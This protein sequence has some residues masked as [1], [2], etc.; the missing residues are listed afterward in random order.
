MVWLSLTGIGV[1]VFMEWR[2]STVSLA[3]GPVG[4]ALFSGLM[5]A[6]VLLLI[7]HLR[8]VDVAWLGLVNHVACIVILWP[9]VIGKTPLPH[10]I[11]VGCPD[12]AGVHAT[13]AAL[14]L[15]CLGGPR[16]WKAMR[17]R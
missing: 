7:R 9:M 1:I 12:R 13:C 4:L 17:L 15:V 16:E 2:V 10:G 5:Y 3:T 14:H 6:A 8:G 11:P